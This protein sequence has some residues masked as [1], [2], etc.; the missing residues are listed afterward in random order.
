GR[1][2]ERMTGA[3]SRA[4]GRSAP[5]YAPGLWAE[6]EAKAAEAHAASARG[7]KQEAGHAYDAAA[8]AYGVFE[9]A[10]QEEQLR[11]HNARAASDNA[12]QCRQAAL[13]LG[14]PQ[15][16]SDVWKTAEAKI[17]DGQAA[18]TE[19]SF[20][21]AVMV[22]QEAAR[23]FLQAEE[24]A[25]GIR[26]RQR[27]QAEEAREAATRARQSAAEAEAE[28]YAPALWKVAS[29]R[30]AASEAAFGKG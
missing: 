30:W 4:E 12:L 10:A 15:A 1:A 23:L 18:I 5:I 14:A 6:A 27:E 13:A 8:A 2:R 16:A 28:Q 19:R 7:D 25:Q 11:E 17:S 21:R 29:S 24:A 22:F 20:G 3:R 26:R 9:T